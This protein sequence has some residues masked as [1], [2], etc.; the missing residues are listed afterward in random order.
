MT[1]KYL[2]AA[3]LALGASPAFAQL[4]GSV[5]VEGEYQPVIIETERLNT[6]P[7][8]Y[9]FELPAANLDY[10]YKGVVSDFH[11][12]LL[13]MGVTGRQTDRPWNIRRGFVDFRLG[14]YINSR[15]HAGYYI[16][17]DGKNTLT[18]D[19]KFT[20]STLYRTHGVPES[21]TRLPRKRLYD[22]KLGLDYSRLVGWEGLLN[23]SLHY[24]AAYF[25]YYGTTTEASM[26]VAGADRLHI[27]SQ[28]LNQVSLSAGYESSP[29][30]IRGWHA[31]ASVDYLGYRRLYSPSY[32]FNPS[33]SHVFSAQKG[34][35]ETQLK[36]G[37]G[38]AF[39]FTETSA[40]ALDADADFLFY[41]GRRPAVFGIPDYSRKNYGV[42]NVTPAYRFENNGL[43]VQ[44]GIDLAVSYNAMAPEEGKHFGAFHVAPDVS[45]QYGSDACVG[46]FILAKGGVTPST[47]SLKEKFDRYQMP[48][49]LST[50]PVFTPLDARVGLNLGPF[51][52]FTGQLDLRY[53]AARNTPL[54]GFYQAFLGAYLPGY[55]SCRQLYLDPYAQ[56]VDL[57][58]ISVG[59][60]L[61][62]AFGSVAEVGFS[63]TFTP[64]NGKK[65]I[66]NGFDRPR[67]ILEAK[68]TVRPLRKLHA[69]LGYAYRG[70][71][72]CYGRSLLPDGNTGLQA[73]RLP[74]VSDLNLK[75]GYDVLD[76][77]EIY[78]RGDNL[79]NRRV[80]ILPGLQAE[81]IVLSGG[82][83]M[84]F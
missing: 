47:L 1:H 19:L 31:G 49:E 45:V 18:A 72:N 24:R 70:V 39:T 16:L 3:L 38:Y 12:G 33:D 8:G 42:I 13:T 76:N 34:D 27:P 5:S 43:S 64:Q 52:G 77:L 36:L 7:Q 83:Y 48:W 63:G 71:R 57:H 74:D 46:V 65:G 21:Y 28:S 67:W 22:G 29:S 14:S 37:G 61:D 10:E 69:D 9:R 35:R 80:D 82:F 6:F 2:I 84:T 73:W 68:A 54:G 75:V 4:S 11:P 20:S 55:T 26:E 17:A 60:D 51:A 59:L 25:N 53:A 30:R 62:Y 50:V 15:L 40:M 56:T 81:G 58:G 41:S 78:F 66:F 23:A 44:A 79:L 32:D